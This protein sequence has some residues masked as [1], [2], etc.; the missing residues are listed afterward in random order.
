MHTQERVNNCSSQR[1]FLPLL[2]TW[3]IE[4][5]TSTSDPSEHSKIYQTT[6]FTHDKFPLSCVVLCTRFLLVIRGIPTCSGRGKLLPSI[7][8]NWNLLLRVCNLIRSWW[9]WGS[10]LQFM[11]PTKTREENS[12]KA[13]ETNV[14]TRVW[15]T[16]F[17]PRLSPQL[18]SL[19]S[20]LNGNASID[21]RM[22]SWRRV[23]YGN[24]F[25][26]SLGARQGVEER[27]RFLITDSF[28]FHVSVNDIIIQSTL[29]CMLFHSYFI[30]NVFISH[31]NFL[32]T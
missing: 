7:G 1:N 26:R 27:A 4:R 18:R 24:N 13:T 29:L 19:T 20:N 9:S 17:P 12:G 6:I 22:T 23:M 28:R 16:K 25:I 32:T 3:V 11:E 5:I 14:N 30:V 8:L 10:W 31:V 21:T 2:A 15:A